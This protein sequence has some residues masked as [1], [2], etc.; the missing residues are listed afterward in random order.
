MQFFVVVD[1]EAG[2]AWVYFD[3]EK[4]GASLRAHKGKYNAY[5]DDSHVYLLTLHTD[6]LEGSDA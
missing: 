6:Q 5:E 3:S 1:L 4:A 2:R